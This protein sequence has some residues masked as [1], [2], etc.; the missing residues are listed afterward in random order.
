MTR[1]ELLAR[2]TAAEIAVWRV[3]E[4]I[5]PFGEMG[6]YLRAGIIASTVANYSGFRDPHAPL[7]KPFEF[8][9]KCEPEEEM[10][11]DQIFAQMELLKAIQNA[12]EAG[13]EVVLEPIE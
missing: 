3:L 10:S 5:E 2:M 12:R 6:A 7:S 4:A 11:A 1:A 8:I 13:G 9:P